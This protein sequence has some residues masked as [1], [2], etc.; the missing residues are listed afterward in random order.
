MP[1]T[2]TT[3]EQKI[4]NYL[5]AK[6]LSPCG[7]A[8]LMGNI[9]AESGFS[10]TNLQNTYEKKLGYTDA[11]Y[12]AAVDNGSYTNFIHDGA[13]YGLCQWT[14]WSLKQAL[15]AYAKSAGRSVGDLEMQLD[16]LLESLAGY[17][18]LLDLLKTTDTVKAA[19][20]AV[21]LNY[22]RPADQGE[23]AKAKRAGFGQAIYDKYAKKQ[24][25]SANKMPSYTNSPLVTVTM[26]SPNRS[27]P[28]NHALDT[29][30]IHCFVGQVTAK[31]GCEVFLP[32]S[33]Q[34]SCN[35][36]VG[37][38]GDIGLC[39]E[40]KD[41]SWCT[42]SSENDNRAVTIEVASD[43]VEPY[44]VTDKAYAALLN[45]VTDI[46]RRNGIKKLVWSTNKNERMKHLNGCNMTVHRDY[47]NKSCPGT[48]LYERHGAIAAE[49]NKRLGASG[50]STPAGKD[51]L[52]RVRK[53]WADAGSQIGAYTLLDN[54]KRSADAHP[55]YSVFDENGKAIYPVAAFSPYTVRISIR[56]L[57]IRSG[58]GK[59]YASRGFISPGI[60]T[61]VEESPGT[62]SS[63]GWGKLKSGAG[64]V[65]LDYCTRV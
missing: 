49:V 25:G 20:D 58:P 33:R 60:Y 42:S 8:G 39:T 38:D 28:R 18:G 51:T 27:S 52:Y 43:T 11:T 15:L 7:A 9:Q 56:D 37:K 17:K 41:R 29:I 26:L 57:Y 21:L 31:R 1:L 14:F 63:T 12:T 32:T 35:Y 4:W 6:G 30:T 64:W 10:S 34:A 53:T 24:E 40:E 23:T 62:G 36:V 47:A 59:G 2:G 46:C 54:A 48:Y 22:E 50:G 65:S 61:I 55:G 16:Y 13:G 45:L 5:I 44:A 19:S 3:N